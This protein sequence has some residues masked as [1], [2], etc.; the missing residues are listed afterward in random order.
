MKLC[1]ASSCPSATA[2]AGRPRFCFS[3]GAQPSVRQQPRPR[4]TSA[5]WN[6]LAGPEHAALLVTTVRAAILPVVHHYL[7]RAAARLLSVCVKAVRFPQAPG[8]PITG[9]QRSPGQARRGRAF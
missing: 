2:L 7:P 9:E 1:T 3:S 8:H 4:H 5:S 6:D